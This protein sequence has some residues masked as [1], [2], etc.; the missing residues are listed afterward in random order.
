MVRVLIVDGDQSVRER[1]R[2]ALDDAE[3]EVVEVSDERSAF[4]ALRTRPD[5]FVVLVNHNPPHLDGEAVIQVVAADR[6]LATQHS[7]L[8]TAINPLQLSTECFARLIG[9][10]G[11]VVRIPFDL[12]ML[13]ELIAQAATKLMSRPGRL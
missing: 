3:Y 4:D 11:S 6:H 7:Y 10:G 13:L 9:L 2:L 5:H 1:L 12:D 8:L